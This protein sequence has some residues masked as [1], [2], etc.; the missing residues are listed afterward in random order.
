MLLQRAIVPLGFIL[1]VVLQLQ[2][3][4]HAI[5]LLLNLCLAVFV[6]LDASP[7]EGQLI[8]L[9]QAAAA[10]HLIHVA[11]AL[12]VDSRREGR[13]KSDAQLWQLEVEGQLAIAKLEGTRLMVQS[14]L[15]VRLAPAGHADTAQ[16]ADFPPEQAPGT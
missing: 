9:A 1:Q 4:G 2:I 15:L 3:A 6:Q 11:S 7:Q 13:C 8:Q 10:F 14:P 5:L 16:R 12:R